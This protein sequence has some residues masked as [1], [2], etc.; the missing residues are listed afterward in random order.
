M[1][2]GYPH[3]QAVAIALKMNEKGCIGPRGGKVC[4]GM[5]SFKKRDLL[6]DFNINKAVN[7][8]E[9]KNNKVY[10]VINIVE[11]NKLDLD[12]FYSRVAIPG[13]ARCS[14]YYM[15][16]QIVENVDKFNRDTEIEISI[17]APSKP[18]RNLDTIKKTYKNI[19][20][21]KIE[22]T[23]IKGLTKKEYEELVN[24]YPEMKGSDRYMRQDSE[25]CSA[26]FEKVGKILEKLKFCDETSS[27]LKRGRESEFLISDED[28]D[29]AAK[30]YKGPI[31]TDEELLNYFGKKQFLFNPK[32]PKKSFDVYIDKNPKDTIPIKYKTYSD[33]LKTIRK[34][35][36]LYKSGK[37][38]HKRIKQVA[39][40]LMVRLRVLKRK[41][42]KS[43]TL[44]KKYHDFLTKRTKTKNADRKK[45]TFKI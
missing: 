45:L 5:K 36:R 4:F 9:I 22:C 38:S 32:N 6:L 20:F 34:L 44:A 30:K 7:Y 23:H 28:I 1:K 13:Y 11:N 18:R 42:K 24:K 19:G 41:K 15:L 12:R 29:E 17:I 14:L 26:K 25:L 39:M 33:T 40:I 2:E 21:D 10:I 35:E 27:S 43:Y 31:P 37:Y 8:Y 3:K 16:K